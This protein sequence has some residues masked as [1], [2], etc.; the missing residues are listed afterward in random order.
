MC[1]MSS[2]IRRPN[3]SWLRILAA[4]L[5]LLPGARLPGLDASISGSYKTF[6]SWLYDPNYEGQSYGA[7]AG[8]LRLGANIDPS[9]RSTVELAY[10]LSPEIRS[11][12]LQAESTFLGLET[13]GYRAFDPPRRL[14][15]WSSDGLNN[16]SLNQEIDR[17]L[18]SFHLS[19]ADLSVGRQAIAWG[20]ARSVNPTDVIV[21]MRFTTLDGEYRQG[22]DALRLRVPFGVAHEV[23][24]GYVFGEDF[25]FESSAAFSRLKLYAAQTDIGVLAVLFKENL[26]LGLDL[27]R[28]IG[29]AGGWL[30]AAYVIPD[31]AGTG[32]QLWTNDYVRL[33]LGLDYNLS[34]NL[35]GYLE[36]HFNSPGAAEAGGYL[37]AEGAP[38]YVE[39]GD[40]LLGR[41]YL[42]LGATY[43]ITP[44]LPASAQLLM[45]LNDFSAVLSVSLEYN[46]RENIY[47]GGGCTLGLGRNPV[48]SGGEIQEYRSEFGA[49]PNLFYTAVK[50]Y[51]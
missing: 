27:A 33:S 20:S 9:Q 28:A 42:D 2:R 35:Y 19:F 41:H 4:V 17:A 44:L 38:A 5:F 15:P 24:L 18:V 37:H 11:P 29:Q 32:E 36:Y 22:V 16:I 25:R 23:D 39:G 34:G 50:V 10:V 47:I 51:F 1:G 31:L 46:V 40:Y 3:L 21:P 48:L 49:Y 8:I 7:A 6:L 14:L 43:S 26:L 45:N 13:G 12:S 30:E